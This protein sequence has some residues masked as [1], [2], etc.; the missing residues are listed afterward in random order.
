MQMVVNPR[1]S[2]AGTCS[3][4]GSSGDGLWSSGKAGRTPPTSSSSESARPA[5]AS[6]ASSVSRSCVGGRAER[7]E[8]V[9]VAH[10]PPQ[11]ARMHRR[12]PEPEPQ[13]VLAPRL[14]LEIGVG[15]AVVI[16]GEGGRA[17]P[18]ERLPGGE[19]LV[20]Q[21]PALGRTALR[22]PRIRR[23]ASSPS[24]ERPA[25]LPRG[26]R[27]LRAPWRA[28]ADGG[29]ARSPRRPPAAAA[30]LRRRLRRAGRASSA[31]ASQGPGSR[32]SRSRAGCP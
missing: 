26:G 32:A 24:A 12:T 31:T 25:C 5:A 14:G 10:D 20:E 22:A 11:Q 2:R 1:A 7:V 21:A 16:A 27:A 15:E 19:V 13:P 28:T 3:S 9:R 18:P 29:A 6:P 23:G 17:R 8:P 4:A 30:S